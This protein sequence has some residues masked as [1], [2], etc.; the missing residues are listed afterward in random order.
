MA[1]A[2]RPVAAVAYADDANHVRIRASPQAEHL[3]MQG[4]PSRKGV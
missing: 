3:T 1:F 2:N 4:G